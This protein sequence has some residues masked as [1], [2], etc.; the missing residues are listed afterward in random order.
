MVVLLLSATPG[1]TV[2]AQ[3]F[4]FE[5]L[6]KRVADYS[7]IIQMKIEISFGVHASEQQ[8]RYLGTI[9]SEDGL[10]MFNG[11][12]LA[13]D[14]AFSSLSG[15]RV[16]TDPVNIEVST[17]DG[18]KYTGEFIGVDRFTRVGFLRIVTEDSV[19]FKPVGFS[20]GSRYEVGSWVGLYMLLPEFIDPPLAADVGMISSLVVT[21]DFFPLTVGFGTLQLTS[22]VFDE[23]LQ[24]LGILGLLADPSAAGAEAASLM[25]SV[26]QF[27]IPLL[28]I[29]TGDRLQKLIADPPARGAVDRGWLG[30]RL[31]ALTSE[32]A[33]F[34]A[35]SVPG[36]IIVNEIING[37]PA[38]ESGLQVGDI[39]YQVDGLPVEIDRD[40]NLLVFQRMIAEM[41][42]GAD[43][44]FS[45]FRPADQAMKTLIIPVT[46]K[47]APLAA[48]DAPEYENEA[49]EFT[50]R[51]LVFDDYLYMNQDPELFKGTIVSKLKQGG[52][53]SVGGLRFGD[54][55]QRVGDVPV[56]SVDELQA[57]MEQLEQDRPREVVFF[58]WRDNQTMFVNIKTDWD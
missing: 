14:D 29:V 41:G 32:M 21:P 47:E 4:D 11:A 53:A 9:V 5:R 8:A 7:V 40:E 56:L 24:P 18:K 31:Q 57:I 36:G 39:I 48:S 35:L 33:E 19:R 16:S 43:V 52:L 55:I 3:Q 22:V 6:Q 30:I 54:V 2:Q 13:A 49:L 28:G 27:G 46:L 23:D 45:V 25:E 44:E 15:F 10:V 50:G 20:S 51:D 1:T 34:W 12:D 37:S 38:E 42:P 26:S 58:I 17:L